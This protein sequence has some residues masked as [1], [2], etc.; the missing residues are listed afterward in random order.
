MPSGS[1]SGACHSLRST[2]VMKSACAQLWCP[3]GSCCR[4]T[5]EGT[6]TVRG[7]RSE[8]APGPIPLPVSPL[9][10]PAAPQEPPRV[11]IFPSARSRVSGPGQWGSPGVTA[12]P[13]PISYHPS[14][15]TENYP[16]LRPG[17]CWCCALISLANLASLN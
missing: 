7:R 16:R 14:P 13:L 6:E 3:K 17:R 5:V 8:R 11:L 15:D 12:L 10:V 1:H 4:G 9:L 2:A